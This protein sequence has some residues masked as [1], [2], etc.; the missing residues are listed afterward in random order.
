MAI[1]P[2]PFGTSTSATD[3]PSAGLTAPLRRCTFRRVSTIAQARALPVYE[4]ACTFPDRKRAVALGDIET[5]RPICASCTFQ[6]I[7]RADSD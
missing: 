6:G 1:M 2:R 3:I 4:V 7:F 5:A